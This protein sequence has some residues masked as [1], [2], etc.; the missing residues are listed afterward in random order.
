METQ[1]ITNQWKLLARK[2]QELGPDDLQLS[3]ILNDLAF[4][5]HSERQFEPAESCYRRSL[6]IREKHLGSESPQ[7]LPN[8]ECLGF[9]LRI[10]DKYHEADALYQR[11]LAIARSTWGNQSI[12][13]ATYQNFL[14]GLYFAWRRYHDARDLMRS[15]R[16]IYKL[17]WGEQNEAVGM[18][19]IAEALL[20][21][22]LGDDEGCFQALADSRD[23][24]SDELDESLPRNLS[25]LARGLLHMGLHED[26]NRVYR[27]G[28]VLQVK[29][30]WPHHPLIADALF[31]LARLYKQRPEVA[32]FFFE[33]G[34]EI[35]DKMGQSDSEK[36]IAA[37]NDLAN[38][39]VDL[40]QLEDAKNL[41]GKLDSALRRSVD[42]PSDLRRAVRAN[43]IK[44]LKL[45]GKTT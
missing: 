12:E 20:L 6:S 25:R 1:A 7:L 24:L 21:K 37:G 17:C 32:A 15:S 36:Y 18:A 31:D 3:G 41:L 23:S 28:L 26:A 45:K 8:L 13:A 11:A 39:L 5:Y 22:E 4:F 33:C 9:L 34:L 38:M 43:L 42:P 2:E 40:G 19:Y 30:I 44:V 29:T 16:H 14:S 10:Q 27:L 35:L